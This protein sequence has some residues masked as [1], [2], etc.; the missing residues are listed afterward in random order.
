M[1]S[2]RL[3]FDGN[4]VWVGVVT[5]QGPKEWHV[6]GVWIIGDVAQKKAHIW[7]VL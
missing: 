5:K 6:I 1:Q 7:R 2:K 3:I 4:G